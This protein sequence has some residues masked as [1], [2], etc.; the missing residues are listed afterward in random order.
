MPQSHHPIVVMGVSGAGKTTIARLIGER[1]G[2]P[3]I[4]ADDLHDEANVA[5]MSAGIPLTDEDRMPWLERVG[6][7]LSQ[8]PTPVIA[9]SALK[10]AY[11]DVL[12]GRAPR[13]RFVMLDADLERLASQVSHREDHFMPPA[14]LQ[15]QLDTL[16]PLEADEPGVVI[17]VDAGPDELVAR[18][19]DALA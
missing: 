14:L 19:V 4:D 8:H 6:N 9:C 18:A 11:R 3:F 1:L 2:M 7:A 10:R 13:T 15:S 16:E 5:K 17:Q 12:R